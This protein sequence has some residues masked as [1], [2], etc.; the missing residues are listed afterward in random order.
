MAREEGKIRAGVVSNLDKKGLRD[1]F[2][3]LLENLVG[4]SSVLEAGKLG[5][6]CGGL[7]GCSDFSSVNSSLK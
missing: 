1:W 4:W 3:W 5:Y 6:Y 7:R 2:T